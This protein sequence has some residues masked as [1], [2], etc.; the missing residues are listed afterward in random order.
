MFLTKILLLCMLCI[1]PSLM[2]DTLSIELHKRHIR[3]EPGDYNGSDIKLLTFGEA[4][5]RGLQEIEKS[6][7][8]YQN[9][10]YLATLY[11]GE[12]KKEMSFIYDTGSTYLWLPLSN[13]TGC[14]SGNL[15]SPASTFENT[16][17]RDSIQYGSGYVEGVV[18]YEVV[19]PTQ[20]TT[21]IRTS[22]YLSSLSI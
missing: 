14:P 18:G 8:N 7:S 12:S 19:A 1:G 17:T 10:Q 2:A 5:G 20:S 16:G 13:C 21:A 6:V 4:K 11:I 22:K 15:Y 9:L 3:P